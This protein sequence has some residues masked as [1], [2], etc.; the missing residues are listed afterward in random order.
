MKLNRAIAAALLSHAL[1]AA[2]QP[3]TPA[4]GEYIYEG[5]AGT[6]TV[7]AKGRFK[8]NTVGSNRHVCEVEGT[9]VNGKSKL[10]DSTCVVSF[11]AGAGQIVVA[12]N[13]ERQCRDNCGMRAGYEGNYIKPT[14]ACTTAGVAASRK[15]FK[16]QYDAKDY[17][18][19]QATLAPVLAQCDK[20]L[21]WITR[22]WLRNDLALAQFRSGDRAACLKTLQPLAKDAAKTDEDVKGDYPPSDGEMYLSV[23]RA[24]RTNLKL[25]RS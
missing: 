1:L 9:I 19:A 3:A 24:A 22:D 16:R 6:L 10:D 18:A 4:A 15:A 20:T 2:A 14:P 17:A 21:A 23:V 11:T 13:D 25:C 5:G 8:I 12:T 7:D